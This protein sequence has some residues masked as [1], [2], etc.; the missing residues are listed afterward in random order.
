M[1]I[2]SYG[3]KKKHSFHYFNNSISTNSI[4][5]FDNYLYRVTKYQDTAITSLQN[6]YKITYFQR[7]NI[8]M[9]FQRL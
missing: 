6:Y 8:V 2:F 9:S 5:C 3:N 1:F 4:L 7:A